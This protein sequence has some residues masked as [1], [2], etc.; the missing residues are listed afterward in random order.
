MQWEHLKNQEFCKAVRDT[1]LCIVPMGVLER[2]GDHMPNGTDCF[3]A[4][5]VACEAAEREPAVVFPVFY[6]GQSNE[7][8]AFPG[9]IS[10]SPALTWNLLEQLLDEIARNGFKKIL[11]Y[12]WHGGNI[13]LTHLMAQCSLWQEKE[14]SLYVYEMDDAL[15]RRIEQI[16]GESPGHAAIW[17]TSVIM[18]LHPE[19]VDLTR[20]PEKRADPMGRLS[21]LQHAY[22]G[23][24]WY[25]DYPE[26]YTNYAGNAN[27]QIGKEL[28][29]A[30]IQSLCECIA[31]VKRDET[32]AKLQKEFQGRAS[33]PVKEA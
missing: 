9:N 23:Y 13:H 22:S 1:Q 11:L 30:H 26:N 7:S 15:C 24:W 18:A 8:R 19:D 33:A 12:S 16:S 10:I 2:H 14:Y 28:L 32:A 5:Y 31:S 3:A 25:A 20:V 6:F 27:A 4:H 17:E 29:E 21:E